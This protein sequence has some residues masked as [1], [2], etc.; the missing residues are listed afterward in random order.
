MVAYPQEL[1][2][3]TLRELLD[4]SKPLRDLED[5]E[6]R[7]L[8]IIIAAHISPNRI[9]DIVVPLFD[10]RVKSA[11]TENFDQ[12]YEWSKTLPKATRWASVILKGFGP[13]EFRSCF[14]TIY[15]VN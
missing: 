7:E 9:I 2:V 6:L 13:N 4:L 11:S 8:L 1:K 14:K 12:E 3:R 10:D 5:Q 15:P